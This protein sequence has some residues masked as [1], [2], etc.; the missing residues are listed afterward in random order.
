MW[1]RLKRFLFGFITNYCYACRKI[2]EFGYWT[3]ETGGY[4]A[5]W[6]EEEEESEEE[7]IEVNFSDGPG[8]LKAYE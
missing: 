2:G 5:D 6:D 7:P 8:G 4:P 3:G 1:Q